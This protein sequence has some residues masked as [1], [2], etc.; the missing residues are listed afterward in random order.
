MVQARQIT[1]T[2]NIRNARKPNRYLKYGT[3]KYRGYNIW[4]QKSEGG[5]ERRSNRALQELFNQP[6]IVGMVKGRT[7]RKM[8][9]IEGI[10]KE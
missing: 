7:L 5:W 1:G 2:S 4:W 3:R 9:H 6:N 10:K 8:S